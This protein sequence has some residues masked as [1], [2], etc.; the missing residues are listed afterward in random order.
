[1]SEKEITFNGDALAQRVELLED[2]RDELVR[3]VKPLNGIVECR[4]AG[5]D[6]QSQQIRAILQNL[7]G[8]IVLGIFDD[9]ANA[10]GFQGEKVG[11]NHRIGVNTEEIGNELVPDMSGG[12]RG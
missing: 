10:A 8:N 7:L 11:L 1:M 12:Q 6:E 2:F 4:W 9:L 5:E 3:T